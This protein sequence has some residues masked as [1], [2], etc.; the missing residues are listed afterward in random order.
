MQEATISKCVSAQPEFK[1]SAPPTGKRFAEDVRAGLSASPKYLPC[2]YFY[3]ARGS[4]LFERITQLPEYYLTRAERE[5]IGERASEIAALLRGPVQ[6]VE[7]GSGT[8]SKTVTLLEA[9]LPVTGDVTYLPID[10]CEDV[11][12]ASAASLSDAVPGV[13]VRPICGRYKE[14][15]GSIAEGVQVLLL[16]LG[17][18]IGN[19][20][21]DAAASFLVSLRD[22]L[23]A[24]DRMLIGIDLAKAPRVLKAAYDDSA[25]VTAEFNLNLLRRINHELGGEFD[26][27]RFRHV[28]LWNPDEGRIE[29]YLESSCCHEVLISSL[30]MTAAFAAGER[31]HT[32]NSHKYTLGEIEELCRRAKLTIER[33]WF[34]SERMFSL[35]CLRVDDR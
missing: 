2:V 17:S 21:R 28:A 3:D 16:W 4:L 24:G 20:D 35:Q 19:L 23:C 14:G 1:S 22:R 6:V 29:M 34:D 18:S 8:S 32:E 13:E 27:D 11:L 33:Q 12:E 15:L 9:L 25:G 30:G 26:L 7:L 31:I 10:V 5:I